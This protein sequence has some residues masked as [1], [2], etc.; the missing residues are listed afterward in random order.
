MG[1]YRD[2]QLGLCLDLTGPDGN[3]FAVMGLG[4]DLARQLGQQEEWK[5]A[6]DAL[7]LMDARYMAF[8]HMFREFF[9]LVTL[10]GFDE[11]EKLHG[12]IDEIVDEDYVVLCE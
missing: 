12:D 4:Q 9:P 10:I 6:T 7:R 5:D 11:I 3:V 8:L 1:M 2:S